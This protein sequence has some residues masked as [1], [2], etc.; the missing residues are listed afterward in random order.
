MERVKAG[1]F[2]RLGIEE[3]RVGHVGRQGGRVK[4]WRRS[5]LAGLHDL[6]SCDRGEADAVPREHD[7]VV[8]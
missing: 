2:A 1:R 5:A 3:A 8:D 7:R 6:A 4:D